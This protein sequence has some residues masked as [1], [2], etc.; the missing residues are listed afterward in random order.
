VATE[1][2]RSP[3]GTSLYQDTGF[4][5]YAPK[6]QQT[7][8]P[9]KSR[10]KGAL[11]R[12]QKRHNRKLS[13][14]RVRVEHALAGVKRSRIVKEVFRNTKEEFSDLVMVVACG[15]PNLRVR[16]RKRRLRT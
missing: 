4:Q 10:A 13:R 3:P 14:V 15:L 7:H 8:Q 9:K 1:P 16:S 5:G 2:I 6:V 11:T 12:G